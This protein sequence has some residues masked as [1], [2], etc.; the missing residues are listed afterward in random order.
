[1]VDFDLEASGIQ[2]VEGLTVF[3]AKPGIVDFIHDYLDHAGEVPDITNYVSQASLPNGVRVDVILAGD[4]ARYYR[5]FGQ[6][7]FDALWQ[8][9]HGSDLF[10]DMRN[11]LSE[12]GYE[13]MLVDSRTGL[14][15]TSELCTLTLPDQVVVVFAPNRQNL[16]GTRLV[17]E[18][19]RQNP[20][21]NVIGVASRVRKTDDEHGG[22]RS[23][24]AEFKQVFE[25][26]RSINSLVSKSDP[27]LVVHEDPQQRLLSDAVAVASYPRSGLAR[28]YRRIARR[29]VA[30]NPRSAHWVTTICGDAPTRDRMARRYGISSDVIDGWRKVAKE[31]VIDSPG[32]I[33]SLA[34][35]HPKPSEVYTWDG[36]VSHRTDQ[37]RML[38]VDAALGF[39]SLIGIPAPDAIRWI[40]DCLEHGQL[41]CRFFEGGTESTSWLR[42]L[43]TQAVDNALSEPA[44]E[45]ARQD[46]FRYLVWTH[47]LH[48]RTD[49]PEVCAA[50]KNPESFQDGACFGGFRGYAARR[51]II[52]CGDEVQVD[53][54]D[55]ATVQGTRSWIR[56]AAIDSRRMDLAKLLLQPTELEERYLS[57]WLSWASDMLAASEL[58]GFPK[59]TAAAAAI[60]A[61]SVMLEQLRTFWLPGVASLQWVGSP[62]EPDGMGAVDSVLV[63]SRGTRPRNGEVPPWWQSPDTDAEMF[64]IN[65]TFQDDDRWGYLEICWLALVPSAAAVLR[66]IGDVELAQELEQDTIK[67]LEAAGLARVEQGIRE[68]KAREPSWRSP[69]PGVPRTDS[70]LSEM[71]TSWPYTAFMYSPIHRSAID[72]ADLFA[73]LRRDH[74]TPEPTQIVQYSRILPSPRVACSC[75]GALGIPR[76]D[77]GGWS[78]ASVG[79]FRSTSIW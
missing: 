8:R 23:V 68:K 67:R 6:L 52:Q 35:A 66:A 13:F 24:L 44:L 38:G 33:W 31:S 26:K 34:K 5:R 16:A 32:A 9:Q 39:T 2:Y 74:E 22:L 28:E 27:W 65:D 56:A 1:M 14:C 76:R 55:H 25:P 43:V 48:D 4:Q 63:E 41:E 72:I 70:M 42:N 19:I 10:L 71:W 17:I 18:R 3:D 78:S 53:W 40:L 36:G 29:I 75:L 46:A 59:K 64:R 15:D 47:T 77:W 60:S 50:L 73:A 61:H 49:R 21:V 62:D 58:R 7:R 45:Q 11:Q 57:H 54:A 37:S 20:L 69:S 79:N 12:L 30:S 51:Y